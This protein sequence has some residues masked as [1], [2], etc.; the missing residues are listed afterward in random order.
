M[1]TLAAAGLGG[2]VLPLGG[3][4]PVN[5]YTTNAQLFPAVAA[6]GNDTFIVVWDSFVQDSGGL[7]VYGQRFDGNGAPTFTPAA[8]KRCAVSSE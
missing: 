2:Q 3:E 6:A 4:F 1:A 5:T 8:S 7:G